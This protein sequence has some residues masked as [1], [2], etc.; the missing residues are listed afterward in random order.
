MRLINSPSLYRLLQWSNDWMIVAHPLSDRAMPI[1][2]E[3]LRAEGE[4]LARLLEDQA[5]AAATR[6][7][8]G[9]PGSGFFWLAY[10]ID[11]ATGVISR[12]A[13]APYRLGRPRKDKDEDR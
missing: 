5:A 2:P 12:R 6:A 8:H 11:P 9:I 10:D 3:R 7:D 13:D 1:A 4:E